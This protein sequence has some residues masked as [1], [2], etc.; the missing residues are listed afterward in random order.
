MSAARRPH[1]AIAACTGLIAFCLAYALP[2]FTQ[3]PNLYYDPLARRLFVGLHPGPLPMG[4]LGQVLY[5]VVAALVAGCVTWA[6]ARRASSSA[7]LRLATAWALTAVALV[8][9]FFTWNNWP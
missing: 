7:A 4:Y 2:S 6:V 8:G 5:G 9:A 3:L 1:A